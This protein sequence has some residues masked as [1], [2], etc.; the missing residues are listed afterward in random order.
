[1]RVVIPVLAV[2]ALAWVA[3]AA[4][5]RRAPRLVP[6]HR[7]EAL[8]FVLAQPPVFDP[9]M[10]VEPSSAL[11]RDR[12][13]PGTA[14]PLALRQLMRFDES[15]VT[16]ERGARIGDYDVTT[17][18]LTLP[19][20][21]TARHWLLVTWMEDGDLAVCTFRFEGSGRE[22]SPEARAWGD[23]LLARIL[24]PEHFRAA[25]LPRVTLRAPRDG[26]LPAFGPD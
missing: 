10:V 21:E 1:L 22:L 15:M 2:V 26:A 17:L 18:W 4:W 12:F 8:C 19:P 25:A 3:I 6:R 13:A 7:A 9:P 23:R 16:A 5:S 11:T 20:G 14:A 24:V